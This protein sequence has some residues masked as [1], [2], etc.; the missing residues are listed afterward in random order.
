MEDVRIA[1]QAAVSICLRFS[2]PFR[3]SIYERFIH[4]SSDRLCK[5]RNVT[6]TDLE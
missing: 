1:R 6:G 4:F 2:C 3:A 5:K